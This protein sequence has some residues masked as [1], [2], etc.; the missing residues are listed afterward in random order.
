MKSI[1]SM[2]PGALTTIAMLSIVGV[3]VFSLRHA[4]SPA[5]RSELSALNACEQAQIALI[6]GSRPIARRDL[7]EPSKHCSAISIRAEQNLAIIASGA[8]AR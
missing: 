2:I 7:L 3:C 4:Y 5:D 6:D 8:A 1:R